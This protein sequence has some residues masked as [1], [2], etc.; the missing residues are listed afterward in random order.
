LIISV[1]FELSSTSSKNDTIG[2]S[3]STIIFED[4]EYGDKN[5]LKAF[6][7]SSENVKLEIV[8]VQL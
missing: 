3:L 5:P 4:N 7:L 1:K 2:A 8:K 6:E